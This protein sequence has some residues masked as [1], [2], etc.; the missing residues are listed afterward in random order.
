MPRKGQTSTSTELGETLASLRTAFRMLNCV[1]TGSNWTVKSL[2]SEFRLS[3]KQVGRYLNT[4]EDFG[5]GF[6]ANSNGNRATPLK[7]VTA[8]PTAPFNG[9]FLTRDELLL[10]YAQ[11][12]GLHHAGDPKTRLQLW[13]KVQANLGVATID[14]AQ[15]QSVIGTFD[16][17]FKSYE[18]KREIIA[19]LLK[20]LYLN[21]SCQVTYLTPDGDAPRTYKIEP[22]ELVEFDRGLYL[23][24]RAPRRDAVILLA[25]ER[26]QELKLNE[27]EFHRAKPVLSAIAKMKANAFGIF[28]D[29]KLLKVKLKFTLAVAFYVKERSWHPSQKLKEYRDGSLTMEFTASGRIEIERWIRGWGEECE[30][31]GMR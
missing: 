4:L 24:C 26:I 3:S 21:R 15:L 14:S 18:G 9:L 19:E 16:K 10:L 23:Y 27:E 17:G 11:L 8:K 1:L 30:V 2:A 6:E 22:Y 12:S 5:I 13:E 28:D 7:V 31:V 29:G 20:A 25:V